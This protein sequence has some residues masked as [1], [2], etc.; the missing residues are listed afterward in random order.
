[1]QI[2]AKTAPMKLYQMLV[3]ARMSRVFP[4]RML[5]GSD[6]PLFEHVMNLKDWASFFS[7]LQLPDDMIDSGYA[8]IDPAD[9]EYVM[10]KNADRIFFGDRK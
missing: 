5:W 4:M 8:K 2:F 10:W 3:D 1:M 9:L 6:Y 7:N